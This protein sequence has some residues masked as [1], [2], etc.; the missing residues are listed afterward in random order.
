MRSRPDNVTP[1]DESDVIVALF[2]SAIILAI[3]LLPLVYARQTSVLLQGSAIVAACYTLALFVARLMHRWLPW[4]RFLALCVDLLL[5]TAATVE[6]PTLN[7][8]LFQLYYIVVIVA[9]MW[10]GR[11]GAV[12]TAIAAIGAYVTAQ[13]ATTDMPWET[14]DLLGVLWDNGAL[15]LVILALVSSY[16]LR[17]RDVEQHRRLQLDHEMQL[18]R[19]LQRQMLPEELPPLEGYDLAVRL[20]AARL[21]SGDMYDF[22]M[23]DERT[24]LMFVADVAGKGVYGM[25]HVSLLHAHLKTA[26]KSGQP[27]ASI[28]ETVNHAG[29][30]ALQPYSFASAF[31]AKL[32]L[33]TGRLVYVNCG[34][35]PPL[36]LRDGATD[37]NSVKH[38]KSDT[39][40]IGVT[41]DPAYVQ[42]SQNLEP[43]DMVVV[44]TDG[45]TEARNKHGDFFDDEGLLDALKGLQ[46]ASAEEVARTIMKRVEEFT[47]DRPHDDAIVVVLRRDRVSASSG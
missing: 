46:H 23:L 15:V 2:R 9:A 25:M 18:A 30:D 22:V 11:H 33:P 35:P 41:T 42:V 16:V 21:V 47:G 12:T 32:D 28:A 10:F 27:P 36:L 4:Q 7:R 39:T 1:D 34:H 3:M 31:I 17:A 29:Y 5:I 13:Y 26:A 40:M 14:R 45:I 44:V 43:G 38:L 6:W 19:T 8:S 24:L 20:Q 37:D